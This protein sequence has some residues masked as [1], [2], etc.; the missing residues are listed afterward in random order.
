[1]HDPM[2]RIDRAGELLHAVKQHVALLDH[3]LV[4]RVGEVW[5]VGLHHAT[6]LVD[7]GVDAPPGDEPGELHV[8]KLAAHA[9]SLQKGGEKRGEKQRLGIPV[10]SFIFRVPLHSIFHISI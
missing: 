4:L 2:S 1:M 10:S 3:A 8:Q 7:L 6:R 5:A 9:K